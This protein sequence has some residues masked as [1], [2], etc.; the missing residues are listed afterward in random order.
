MHLLEERAP[1]QILL[2]TAT[3]AYWSIVLLSLL[4]IIAI[5]VGY[6]PPTAAPI[7]FTANGTNYSFVCPIG[8]LH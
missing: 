5:L 4:F 2:R 1:L 8:A 3:L 7:E 6:Q